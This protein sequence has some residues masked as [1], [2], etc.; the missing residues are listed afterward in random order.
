MRR[1]CG[2]PHRLAEAVLITVGAGRSVSERARFRLK[3]RRMYEKSGIVGLDYDVVREGR[4]G[5]V[6][7]EF[8]ATDRLRA[9]FRCCPQPLCQPPRARL[10]TDG[11]P[12]APPHVR[13]A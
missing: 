4:A 1:R 11:G 12:M 8:P 13:I 3:N 6:D 2:V 9:A 10:E 5:E 7:N